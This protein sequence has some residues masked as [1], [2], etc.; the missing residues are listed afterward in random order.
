MRKK[1]PL[2]IVLVCC[3]ELCIYLW[4]VWTSTLDFGHFFA[5]QSAF[6]FDKCARLSGRVSSFLM[7]ITLGMLGYYGLKKIYSDEKK[8]ESFLILISLFACNHLIHLLFVM[9]N[10]SSHGK[11]IDIKGPMEIGGSIHGI[12]TFTSIL[13]IPLLLW[14]YQRLS[15]ALYF[16]ILLY[17]LNISSF[18]IKT[19]LG[20]I[21]LPEHPAYHNQ[22]GIALISAACIYILYR[23]YVEH[24]GKN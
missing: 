14:N 11:S 10:L 9:L 24:T 22:L 8:K 15:K 19:F 16:V 1:L 17:L 13:I 21:N 23:V 12:I 4:S 6:I 20:K 5:I 2:L 7:L 18:I 3:I